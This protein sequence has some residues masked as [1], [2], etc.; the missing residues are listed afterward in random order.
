MSADPYTAPV[1]ALF[2]DTAHSGDLPGGV[3]VVAEAQG[4]RVRLT[5]AVRGGRLAGLRFRAFG[6]PH[7][8]AACELFCRTLEGRAAAG[9]DGF[10]L[11]GIMR[12][13]SVPVEKT[14]RILVL[15][16]AVRMLRESI[17]DGPASQSP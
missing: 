8:I 7:L 12:D 5:A 9:L 16:D 13:L 17:G 4:V 2:A 6:C 10:S 11:A 3:A 1:R 15:E 14:G